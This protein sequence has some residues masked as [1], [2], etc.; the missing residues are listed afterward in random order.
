MSDASAHL[1]SAA[2]YFPPLLLQGLLFF[3]PLNSRARQ[4]QE[5]RHRRRQGHVLVRNRPDQAQPR[6]G[7]RGLPHAAREVP[8]HRDPLTS[9]L[10]ILLAPL[11][12]LHSARFYSTFNSQRRRASA[13]HPLLLGICSIFPS[14]GRWARQRVSSPPPASPWASANYGRCFTSSKW[15]NPT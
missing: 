5:R 7:A 3:T 2:L 9:A 8:R 13:F 12:W 10:L 6:P 14:M 1:Y 11:F 15:R 4:A